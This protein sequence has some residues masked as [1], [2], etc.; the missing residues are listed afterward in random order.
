MMEGEWKK[1]TS[2]TERWSFD[3]AESGLGKLTHQNQWWNMNMEIQ[4]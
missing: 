4:T 2:P 1:S 3:W